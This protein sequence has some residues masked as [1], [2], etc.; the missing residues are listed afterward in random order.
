[1]AKARNQE[2]L[3]DLHVSTRA[4]MLRLPAAVFPG[5]QQG[6]ALAPDVALGDGMLRHGQWLGL[7]CAML[8]LPVLTASLDSYT[9]CWGSFAFLI[10][11]GAGSAV[12]CSID[13]SQEAET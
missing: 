7:L 1:M 3:P 10:L 2:L 5:A 6:A 13:A 11:H 8:A 12:L 9:F 4:Q